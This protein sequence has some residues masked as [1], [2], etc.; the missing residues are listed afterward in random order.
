MEYISTGL[1]YNDISNFFGEFGMNE[2]Y[3][4]VREH[5]RR[6]HAM[7]TQ[8]IH[9]KRL[10]NFPKYSYYGVD[11]DFG[12]CNRHSSK[13]FLFKGKIF[14]FFLCVMLFSCYLYGGQDLEKGAAMA[15]HDMCTQITRLEEK[16]PLVKDAMGYCRQGYHWVK[17]KTKEM[18]T[19]D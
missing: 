10:D 12:D 18:V 5:L 7:N 19:W 16:E 6:Q 13:T 11:E 2:M 1:S 4:E 9:G 3:S 14:L 17:D 8:E 15:W